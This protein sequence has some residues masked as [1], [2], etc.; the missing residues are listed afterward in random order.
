MTPA[1]PSKG[2]LLEKSCD[3]ARKLGTHGRFRIPH[4]TAHQ[5]IREL[6]E[7][8]RTALY[9]KPAGPP[10]KGAPWLKEAKYDYKP[11]KE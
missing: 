3:L 10:V 5:Q 11:S 4:E 8:K 1:N 9:K 6:M 7:L 2:S